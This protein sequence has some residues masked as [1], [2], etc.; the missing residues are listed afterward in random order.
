[1][2]SFE[3]FRA[4]C[5]DELVQFEEEL[6]RVLPADI[7]NR[8]L[9]ITKAGRHLSL[10]VA[11]NEFMNL[12]RITDPQEA[13][14]KHVFDSVAPWSY[15]QNAKQ[16]MDAGTGAGFP[17]IPLSIV[18]PH[19]RFVLTDSTQKKARFVDAVVDS[20]QLSNVSV[21]A[22]RAEH[23]LENQK[24]E[25]VAAR[26]VAPTGEMIET[27]KKFLKSGTRLLLYKGPDV[28]TELLEAQKHRVQSQLISKYELP[29]GF[30]ARSLIEVRWPNK[31][32]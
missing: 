32:K 22:E 2:D 14:A 18:L 6:A 26:A 16:V 29:N 11:A 21:F 8:D 4:R 23:L 13:A 1:M 15:L 12:T 5:H 19:V 10:I 9:L 31:P 24:S 25:I 3:R 30:G 27:F 28:E 20:L 7:P 17:G